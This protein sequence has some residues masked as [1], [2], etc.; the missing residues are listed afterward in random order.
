MI[1][2]STLRARSLEYKVQLTKDFCNYSLP[3]FQTGELKPIID[4]VYDW[5]DVAEAH[6]YMEANLNKGKIILTISG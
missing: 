6:R 5:K 3:K 1:V 4:S 2:G